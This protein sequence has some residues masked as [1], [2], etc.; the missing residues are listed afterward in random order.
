M[1]VILIIFLLLVSIKVLAP[2]SPCLV[3]FDSQGIDPF[4][5][6]R[7]A[8]GMVETKLDT[9]AINRQERAYGYYQVRQVRLNDYY[10]R[11]GIRY[12]LK[13][14]LDYDKAEKVFMYY[15]TQIGPYDPSR[16]ARNWNGSGPKTWVYWKK[17][18][19]VLII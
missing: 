17:V 15:A 19:K 16:I 4:R 13:D 11:T 12:S 18:K 2:S 6:L 7:Y 9:L 1:K 14:M 10:K 8:I 5:K 3:I